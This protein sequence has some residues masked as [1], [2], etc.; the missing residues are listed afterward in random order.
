[1]KANS[2]GMVLFSTSKFDHIQQCVE[3]ATVAR[4][5]DSHDSVIECLRLIEGFFW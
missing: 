3:A 1:V 5:P 4:C 2:R